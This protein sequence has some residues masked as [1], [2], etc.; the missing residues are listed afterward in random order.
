MASYMPQAP[1]RAEEILRIPEIGQLLFPARLTVAPN[2]T[3][4]I[5]RPQDFDFAEVPEAFHPESGFQIPLTSETGL[6]FRFF[7]TYRAE[8]IPST[9]VIHFSS[10]HLEREILNLSSLQSVLDGCLPIFRPPTVFIYD[11]YS[12]RRPE[13]NRYFTGPHGNKHPIRLDWITYYDHVLVDFLGRRRFQKLSREADVK[14][15]HGGL[16]ILLQSEPF[17][18]S[19][20]SH[21]ERRRRLETRFGTRDFE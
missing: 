6:E 14:E 20:R 11:V 2:E 18:E 19:N 21:S 4:V 15:F 17:N 12:G 1:N 7:G 13:A 10:E 8:V 3:I 9:I 5:P 16:L